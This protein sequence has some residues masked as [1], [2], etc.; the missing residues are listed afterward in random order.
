MEYEGY[1]EKEAIEMLE[2]SNA[3]NR[4]KYIVCDE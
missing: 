3:E 1:S 2:E 4:D